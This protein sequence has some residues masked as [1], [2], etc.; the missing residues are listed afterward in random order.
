MA[1]VMM[2]PHF[3]PQINP[4]K[5]PQVNWEVYF[6]LPPAEAQY[7]LEHI[8][9]SKVANIMASLIAGLS[10]SFVAVVLRLISRRMVKTPLK[11][12]D[13]MMV[14]ALSVIGVEVFYGPAIASVKI[15]TLLLFSRI[16]PG[17][18][19]RLWLWSVG[20]FVAIYSGIQVLS[21]IFQCRPI[22]GAWNPFIKAQCIQIN[23]VFMILAGMNVLTD[24]MLLIA[25]LPAIW[26]L[27]MRKGMKI[28]LMSIFCIGG[29]ICVVS[30]YRIPKLHGLSLVDAP[31]SNADATIWSIVEM[32]VAIAC[33]CAITLRPAFNWVFRLGDSAAGSGKSPKP[34]AKIS[35]PGFDR[36]GWHGIGE[37]QFKMDS[38]QV[39]AKDEGTFVSTTESQSRLRG[40]EC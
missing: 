6:S 15:S 38:V 16:F 19:F 7:Q 26:G 12:D 37:D 36:E 2:E 32:C 4:L 39:R 33:S 11:A 10:I 8:D 9:E 23:L 28:Q 24:F 17:R 35:Y 22:Q 27:Q 18:H 20:L 31:W 14:A 1:A 25:P 13:W 3:T 5:Y 21:V 30:I 29:F 40:E 34:S